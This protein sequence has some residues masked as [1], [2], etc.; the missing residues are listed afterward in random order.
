MPK[1]LVVFGATG[2]QGSSVISNV[3]NDQE[4]SA[5]YKIRAITRDV[6]SDKAKQLKDKVEVIYG[7]TSDKESLGSALT[8][9]HTVFIMT[10]PSFGANP[11]ETEVNIVK[12]IADAA[13][14][15]GA[16]YLIYSTLPSISQLSG[17]K[18]TKITFFDAKA[19]AESYVRSLNIKSAFFAGGFFMENFHQHPFL[20]PQPGPDG[21]WVISRSCSSTTK[22]PYFDATKDTGK[23][24]GTI[25]ANP[26]EY[27]GKTFSAAQALYSLDEIAA[28]LSQATGKKVVYKQLSAEEFAQSIP[29]AGEAFSEFFLFMQDY[30]GYFGP[31]TEKLVSWAAGKARGK[32]T[33]LD[34]Y[35]ERHPLTLG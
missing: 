15:Q 12:A 4:L 19:K 5:E 25:L 33:T 26:Y 35:F 17:G 34:D 24:I 18:C 9:A 31:E 8:G 10:P 20:G 32:L 21:T 13:V 6:N 16:T 28:A 2:H 14:Q 3:L 7:D 1:I 30:G 29:V 22:L 23:W 11:E 27:E